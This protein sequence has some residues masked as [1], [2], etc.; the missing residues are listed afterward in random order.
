MIELVNN[1]FR[2]HTLD[3]LHDVLVFQ[4]ERHSS[5]DQ[6]ISNTNRI[7]LHV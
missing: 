7:Y 6:Q 1:I 5:V 3:V 2:Y 4:R